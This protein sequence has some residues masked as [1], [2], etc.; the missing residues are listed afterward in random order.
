MSQHRIRVVLPLIGLTCA[1][2]LA[3]PSVGAAPR[4]PMV[5]TQTPRSAK[6]LVASKA[7]TLVFSDEFNGSTLDRGKWTARDW[8]RSGT[9]P[10]D[11]WKYD[12]ANVAPN[13]AGNLEIKVR[14]PAANTYTGGLVDSN[15]KFDYTYGTLEARVKFP[16]TNGHLGAV[17]VL[18]TAGLSPGGVYDGTARDGAEMD[19]VETNSQADRY[20]VSLHW[21]SFNA[22]QHQQSSTVATAPGV[23]SGYHTVGLN[24]TATKLEFTYDGTVVRTVVDPKLISQVKEYPLLSHEILD[25]W[26][27]GSI[28]DEVF[29]SS[30][31]FYVDYIRVWQ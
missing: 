23:H 2:L 26:A 20:T 15:G 1:A 14:N 16:P 22:P 19:I 3:A 21:D 31:S 18:P 30:S 27:D 13:G 8:P 4:A 7:K 9:V 17:W 6:P 10:P 29:D 12:P 24:W 11:T 25:Q 5:D 28:H